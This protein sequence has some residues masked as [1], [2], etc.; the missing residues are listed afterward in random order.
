M[1]LAVLREGHGLKTLLVE[2][3]SEL[4]ASLLSADV[5]DELFLT[6]APKVKL[7]RET[8]TLTGGDALARESMRRFR[9]VSCQPVGDE[10]FLRYRRERAV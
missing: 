6:L 9:L 2:G 7:G 3:G 4:N 1:I 8:P 10:V 5:V